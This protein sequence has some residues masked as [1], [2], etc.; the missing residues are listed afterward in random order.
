MPNNYYRLDDEEVEA[1]VEIFRKAAKTDSSL[2]DDKL[3]AKL[4]QDVEE[5]LVVYD[6]EK[7]ATPFDAAKIKKELEEYKDIVDE[8][9]QRL[10][11][12][13]A[14]LRIKV[15]S[16][17]K[18]AMTKESMKELKTNLNHLS[19][20]LDEEIKAATSGGGRTTT[21]ALYSFIYV[22]DSQFEE[23]GLKN[24]RSIMRKVLKVIAR[25]IGM[26]ATKWNIE[27]EIKDAV[28]NCLKSQKKKRA[29]EYK[30]YESEVYEIKIG[31]KDDE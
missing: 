20:K 27:D 14:L 10:N 15:N 26:D 18:R 5:A 25:K 22:L 9:H 28:H 7:D 1:L 6:M 21:P 23:S 12:D 19:A 24:R 4:L 17:I 3:V 16:L 13:K 31:Y 2:P 11:E 29:P 8:L 30:M